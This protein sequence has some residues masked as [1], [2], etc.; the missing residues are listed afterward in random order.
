MPLHPAGSHSGLRAELMDRRLVFTPNGQAVI[1]GS[2][3]QIASLAYLPNGQPSILQ[4]WDIATGK[5]TA[6]IPN[7]PAAPPRNINTP[8]YGIGALAVSPD[9]KILAVGGND[10]TVRLLN[11]SAS[12]LKA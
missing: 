4:Q 3:E 5:V 2:T 9:G 1:G 12:G 6:A 7:P 8:A 10:G 11:I